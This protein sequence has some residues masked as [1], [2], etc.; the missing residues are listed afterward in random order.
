MVLCVAL[1]ACGL[2]DYSL[3]GDKDTS[4]GGATSGG[5][6]YNNYDYSGLSKD[7]GLSLNVDR[8]EKSGSGSYTYVYCTVTN[9]SYLSVPT[10]YR[11]VKVKAQFKDF[12]GNIVE[13]D[14]TY[15]VDSM[16]LEP[17]ESKTFYYMVEN[18][19]IRSASLSFI[20]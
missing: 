20:D 9:R 2:F 8:I 17:G 11:Y 1:S 10:R 14:W 12:S 3:H 5:T 16:W 18:K 6:S 15:A 4:T 13:T 19:Y 7:L